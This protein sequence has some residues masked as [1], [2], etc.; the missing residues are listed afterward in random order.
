[1]D[2]PGSWFGLQPS[3]QPGVDT[4]GRIAEPPLVTFLEADVGHLLGAAHLVTVGVPLICQAKPW[5]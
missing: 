2:K 4:G 1:M 3:F 5:L